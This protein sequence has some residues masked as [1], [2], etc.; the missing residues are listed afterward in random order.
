MSGVQGPLE[1][2]ATTSVASRVILAESTDTTEYNSG[3]LAF[4]KD[5]GFMYVL[6]REANSPVDGFNVLNITPRQGDGKG[7]WIRLCN[8]CAGVTGITG[9]TF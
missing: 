5:I 3:E 2:R 1:T 4:C 9:N 6:V 7:R 8:Y